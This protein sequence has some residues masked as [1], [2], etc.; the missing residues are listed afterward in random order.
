LKLD[1]KICGIRDMAAM[2]AAR[3][4]GAAFVGFIFY[5]RSP[6]HISPKEAGDLARARGGARSVAVTVDLP[7]T[8]IAAIL[9]SVPIDVIQLHGTETPERVAAVRERFKRPVMKSVAIAGPDDVARAQAYAE[10]ADRLLFDAK[11]PKD[12][13]DALP[14]GNALSFDWQLLAGET[15]AV[16]WML[17]GGLNAENVRTAAQASGAM[18]VDVSSGV[19][20]APGVKDPERIA[21]FL[22]ACRDAG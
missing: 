6:R 13:P 15:W 4:N 21:A 2:A 1:A 12:D 5:P 20:S 3:D 17:S 18:A 10:T 11:P 7:D 16:P 19:E 22:A 9:D 14:G 8:Q